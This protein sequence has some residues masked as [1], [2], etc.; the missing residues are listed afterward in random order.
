MT[1]FGEVFGNSINDFKDNFKSLFSLGFVGMFVPAILF[2]F[3][4]LVLNESVGYW[5]AYF[6]IMLISLV[7]SIYVSIGTLLIA[8]KGSMSLSE[9]FRESSPYFWKV[10]GLGLVLGLL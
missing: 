5:L 1:S 4:S 10:V 3:V 7:M 9:T 6:I 8:H 2:L